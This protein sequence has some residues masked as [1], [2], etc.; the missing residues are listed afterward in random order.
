MVPLWNAPNAS[1]ALDLL[2][3][4][5]ILNVH[6]DLHK[7]LQH[8]LLISSILVSAKGYH[9]SF[10]TVT[11]N[12]H[13]STY[14]KA[15]IRAS[16]SLVMRATLC[17]SACACTLIVFRTSARAGVMSVSL[18]R[19]APQAALIAAWLP[20]ELCTRLFPSLHQPVHPSS[21]ICALHETY[22]ISQQECL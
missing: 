22:T 2:L 13:H 12:R 1:A 21:L 3:G 7:H 17:S 9:L 20:L 19:Y 16:V 15:A 8:R 5:W 11:G 10:S 18:R 14:S 4:E 6:D